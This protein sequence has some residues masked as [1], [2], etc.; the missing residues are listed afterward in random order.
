MLS[1]LPAI[2]FYFLKTTLQGYFKQLSKNMINI[3]QEDI[4]P[5]IEVRS[6]RDAQESAV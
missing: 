5:P 2:K 1:F 6:I 4:G 3:Y